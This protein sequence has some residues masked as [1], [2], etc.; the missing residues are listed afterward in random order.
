MSTEM[1]WINQLCPLDSGIS[2]AVKYLKL[3]DNAVAILFA[4]LRHESDV[5]EK[6]GPSWDIET[7]TSRRPDGHQ[8]TI[9]DLAG[10]LNFGKPTDTSPRFKLNRRARDQSQAIERN[11]MMG[12][13]APDVSNT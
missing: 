1:F 10:D 7:I 4:G 5:R 13:F 8:Q 12:F 9:F 3:D 11:R 2:V 6:V